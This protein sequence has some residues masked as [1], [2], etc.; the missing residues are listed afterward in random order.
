MANRKTNFTQ[1]T[2]KISVSSPKKAPLPAVTP[3][4]AAKDPVL[5]ILR[6]QLIPRVQNTFFRNQINENYI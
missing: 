1:Y 3:R 6:I 2:R 4:I 5:K